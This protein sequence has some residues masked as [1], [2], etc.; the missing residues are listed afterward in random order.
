MAGLPVSLFV[1][2]AAVAFAF[3]FLIG[4]QVFTAVLAHREKRISQTVRK[5]NDLKAHLREEH[6]VDLPSLL[7]DSA[8]REQEQRERERRHRKWWPR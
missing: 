3:G 8:D 4:W 5:I 2:V 6:D 1:L 7:A